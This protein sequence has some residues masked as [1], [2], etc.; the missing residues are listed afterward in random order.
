[1]NLVDKIYIIHY[2][3]S[4]QRRLH[5]ENQMKK[6]FPNV[7]YEFVEELDKEDLSSEIKSN[8][9]D[10]DLFE[11]KFNREMLEAEMSLCMKYKAAVDKASKLD[12]AENVFIL[13]D[14]VVFKEDPL[15]YLK[16]MY[17]FCSI[18]NIEYDCV[19]LGEA[20]I[21]KGDSQNIFIKKEYPSTNGLCTVLYK[22][23]SLKKLNKLLSDTK[24][25]QPMD[26]QMNDS[27]KDLD[28]NVYWGKAI[29]K[30]GSVLATEDSEYSD[31]KSFLRDSY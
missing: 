17:G 14:D 5:M 26:W 4:K 13:E 8:N 18:Q 12:N 3:K 28:F 7:D 31:L 20:W 25:H 29:T 16:M 30:H 24:I 19:F 1:M 6:W 23:E 21:R 15:K 2:T 10:L 22:K 9:F 11:S 27:L